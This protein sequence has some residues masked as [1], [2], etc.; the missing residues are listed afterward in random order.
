MRHEFD[1]SRL[2]RQALVLYDLAKPIWVIAAAQVKH[3]C[4]VINPFPQLHEQDQVLRSQ[5][6][7]RLGASEIEAP[8]AADFA[9]GIFPAVA[10]LL[11]AVGNQAYPSRRLPL[12]PLPEDGLAALEGQRG[13]YRRRF[14]GER[15]G[16][17]FIPSIAPQ[18]SDST[19]G[20]AIDTSRG[21]CRYG[22]LNQLPPR[23]RWKSKSRAKAA[24]VN[25]AAQRR[26]GA[27]RTR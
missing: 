7:P 8:S 22:K 14:L 12:A 3:P 11:Q 20:R 21:F 9:L 16:S 2:L 1:L 5:I 24:F 6:E 19:L 4:S 17:L 25:L 23:T 13:E 26:K 27:A 18:S 10:A 15:L